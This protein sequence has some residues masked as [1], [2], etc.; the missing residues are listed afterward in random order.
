MSLVHESIAAAQKLARELDPDPPHAFQVCGNALRLFDVTCELH[1]LGAHERLLLEVAALL[2]DIG[3][4]VDVS[5]HHKHARDLILAGSIPALSDDDKRMIACIARYHRKA[6]PRPKHRVYRDLNQTQQDVVRKLA[7][8]LRIGDG[9][10]RGH[11][12]D[13]K[14]IDMSR[15]D[16]E[17]VFQIVLR[18]PGGIDIWG[19]ERKR[20]LFEEEFGVTVE[21]HAREEQDEA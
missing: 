18:R 10:D 13:V 17:I 19:A 4:S 15:E 5:G 2:H 3:H 7:A 8:L 16:N 14:G 9:L 11:D 12:A 6:H 21:F 20:Q 1:E